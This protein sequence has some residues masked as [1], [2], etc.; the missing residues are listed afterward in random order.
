MREFCGTLGFHDPRGSPSV[1]FYVLNQMSLLYLNGADMNSEH[2]KELRKLAIAQ[3]SMENMVAKGK[4][5]GVGFYAQWKAG[6]SVP[7]HFSSPRTHS[8]LFTD[9]MINPFKLTEPL[10][11]GLMMSMLGI[12]NEQL[13][14]YNTALEMIGVTNEDE[15]LA[16]CKQKYADRV[17][18]NVNFLKLDQLPTS[19]FTL[20]S[21]NPKE[22]VFILK[23]H[24]GC[25]TNTHY[26]E[27]EVDS[28]VLNNGCIWCHH[29]PSRSDFVQVDL[30]KSP[31]ILVQESI[32]KASPLVVKESSSKPP[33][34]PQLPGFAKP[35]V[36][37][38]E[39]VIKPDATQSNA[40]VQAK[41]AE[42]TNTV[43]ANVDESAKSS[44]S[45]P[46]TFLSMLKDSITRPDINKKILINLIGITGAGK[47]T[48]AEK[49]HNL[50]ISK[51][52]KCLIINSDKWAKMGKFGATQEKAAREEIDNFKNAPGN[53]KAIIV[54][55]CNE[56][57]PSGKVY[58]VDFP[59]Y[60]SYNYFPN[61][62][63]SNYVDY[64][65]WCIHN[66]LSRPI[67][68]EK[69]SFYLN[70]VAAGVET[71]IKVHNM[72]TAKLRQY[73]GLCEPRLFYEKL[74][75][76]KI[77]SIVKDGVARY[78]QYL[79]MKPLDDEV[80]MFVENVLSK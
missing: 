77:L 67:H 37:E 34:F 75:M 3:T 7:M 41:V 43:Q 19:L 13:N 78:S 50:M 46:K 40:P 71:C 2:M 26:S 72:K 62:D 76:W 9:Q 64:E 79:A 32:S 25:A 21:F 54:D 10:W 58:G 55:M 18:G 68:D 11:W 63:K 39:N 56:D 8:S 48:V 20:D 1:I 16:Y 61:L 52:A 33:S 4:Y 45:V 59:E 70:P 49:I 57:G 31:K 38:Q 23:P 14:Y 17:H 27:E 47:S 44:S 60:T 24:N 51:G 73:L 42:Q 53:F 12:F 28:Y 5:C 35:V 15:F 22:K 36:V 30:S 69:S 66:V 29:V 65:C 6:K 80:R 74:P